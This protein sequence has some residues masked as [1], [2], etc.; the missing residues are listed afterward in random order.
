LTIPNGALRF[1]PPDNAQL[2]TNSPAITAAPAT[3]SGEN[4]AGGPGGH[5]G[6][7]HAHGEHPSLHTIYVLVEEGPNPKLRAV[8]VKTGISDGISTEV[9]SGLDEGAK[10]VT[11]VEMSGGAGAAPG[12]GF[13]G[14]G[15]PRMR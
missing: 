15:F 2:D 1:R 6:N 9:I 8:Q 10:V 4:G 3:N 13:G 7:G 14:G 11:S 12:G 5:H